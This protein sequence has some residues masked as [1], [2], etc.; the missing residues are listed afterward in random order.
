MTHTILLVVIFNSLIGQGTCIEAGCD[1][2][3]G[4]HVILFK[5][6]QANQ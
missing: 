6:G 3:L 5:T 2:F 1:G 4:E